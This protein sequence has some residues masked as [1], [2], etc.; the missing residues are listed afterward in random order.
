MELALMH[1]LSWEL[2]KDTPISQSCAVLNRSFQPQDSENLMSLALPDSSPYCYIRVS[3][4]G[5]CYHGIL[6]S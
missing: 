4:L 1:I 2:G 6:V 5:N 3:L